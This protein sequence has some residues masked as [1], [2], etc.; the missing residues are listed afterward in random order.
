MAAAVSFPQIEGGFVRWNFIGRKLHPPA[1]Y[2]NRP[3][4]QCILSDRIPGVLSY[5]F[6][7][8]HH[9][10][11]R[12]YKIWVPANFRLKLWMETMNPHKFICPCISSMLQLVQ[13]RILYDNFILYSVCVINKNCIK[14]MFLLSDILL[15]LAFNRHRLTES[16]L[17]CLWMS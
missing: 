12:L 3:I 14:A 1:R 10:I 2:R 7:V 17:F 16:L 8:A 11:N 4:V 6:H 9:V 15:R 13:K 5:H